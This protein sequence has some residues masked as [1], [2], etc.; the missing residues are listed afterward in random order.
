M[1]QHAWIN[2]EWV[3]GAGRRRELINPATGEIMQTIQETSEEQT[4]AAIEAAHQAFYYSDWSKD[5]KLRVKVMNQLADLM[6][7]EK[8]ALAKIETENTGKPIKEARI[9]VEDSIA[10][11]RYYAHFIEEETP[12]QKEMEDGTVSRV[13]REPV[14]VCGLIVPWNFPLLLGMWKLAPALAA[15][16]TI[17][18]KPSE[19]TPLSFIKLAGLI[20]Q[21]G[22]PKGV[23]N[24]ILGA[25]DPVGKTI[26]ESDK[27]NKISFTG[28]SET[29]KRINE[30]CARSLKRVSLE[31]GG[32]SPLLVLED[33]DLDL[34]AEWAAYGAFFNQGEVCVASSR[35]LVQDKIYQAFIERL[36]EKASFIQIGDPL[37]ER[38]EMGPLISAEHVE[39]VTGYISKGLSEGASLLYGGK[40][41][42]QPGYFLQPTIFADVTQDMQIVQ[43]EIFGPV[44]TIQSFQDEAEA[45]R[46]ANGT[47]FGL[48]AGILSA[49]E[50]K[51]AEI[52]AKLQAGTI[53]INSYHTPYVETSW[54]GYKQSGIGRELGP[55]G[56]YGFT[57][58]KHINSRREI[59]KL[60]WCGF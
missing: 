60:G 37:N 22:M 32:K 17:V 42:K 52:A 10:C 50:E 12:W 8:E 11:L 44:V 43:E 45:I 21:S 40:T 15:G 46:L 13:I 39:K 14:G 5:Q 2:G 58:T 34:A 54:G 4:E 16:N 51:A 20:H 29:G 41:L 25:G 57:E 59:E 1:E 18:F 55:Q 47:K 23:F 7:L 28:G 27:V 48:A 19:W 33:A 38:T 6:D 24:L 35:I 36:A 31:L 53:W 3:Q 30:Q 26:V 49:D 9:D 56:Y